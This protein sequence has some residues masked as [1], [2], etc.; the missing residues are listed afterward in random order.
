M[1]LLAD[2]QSLPAYSDHKI[3]SGKT[4]RYAVTAVKSNRME[5]KLSE[6][7]EVTAP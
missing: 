6:P 5:S 3:E 2:G 1:E 4:Y 7:M